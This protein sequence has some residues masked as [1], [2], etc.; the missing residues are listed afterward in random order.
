[1]TTDIA[2]EEL[3]SEEREAVKAA[4]IAEL[5]ARIPEG[6]GALVLTKPACVQCT[7]TYRDLDAKGVEYS[8]EDLADDL[9]LLDIAKRA[10]CLQAPVV[11]THDDYWTGFRPDKID[12]LVASRVAA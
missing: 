8:I 1:M 12:E 2:T 9:E 3:T 10:G 11:I 4:A 6:A 5:R 7:A